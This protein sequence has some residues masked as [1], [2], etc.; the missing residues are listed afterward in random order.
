MIVEGF[1]NATY[2]NL[3]TIDIV[4][5]YLRNSNSPYTIVDSA[6]SIIDSLTFTGS[7]SFNNAP[8]G[9]YYIILK[10]RNSIETWSKRKGE[11]L[12]KGTTSASFNFTYAITQALGDHMKQVD[13]SP[14]RFG[15]YSG[16][17]NQDGVIEATDLLLISNDVLIMYTGMSR[18]ILMETIS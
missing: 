10:H 9:S 3:N 5:V 15:I 12:T 8:S 18:L 16:D 7:F 14:L 17:V 6:N 13:S 1:Y 4:K 2:N 11:S